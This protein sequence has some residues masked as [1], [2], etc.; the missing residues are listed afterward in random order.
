MITAGSLPQVALRQEDRMRDIS[1]L[2]GEHADLYAAIC[3]DRDF[4][5]QANA[6]IGLLGPLDRAPVTL[7]L[8][9]GP[10]HHSGVL[11]NRFGAS[12]HC[13]DIAAEMRDIAI[14]EGRC[15]Y[16]S[17][18][19]GSVPDALEYEEGSFDLIFVP[20][21]SLGYLDRADLRRTLS[22]VGRLLRESGVF[23]AELH[24]VSSMVHGLTAL[25]IQ[26]REVGF[27]GGMAVCEWP[28]ASPR[29]DDDDWIVSMDVRI[30]VL[31][32]GAPAR[33]HAFISRERI[34]SF[35]EV[36]DL[37][38][39]SGGLTEAAVPPGWTG[40]FPDAAVVV[41]RKASHV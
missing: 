37:A 24:R 12:V 11:R 16:G 34:Y 32:G 3:A 27:D 5:A 1:A 36:A 35:G 40:I 9:A 13:I 28:A 8:F 4:E 15:A 2:Y 38:F 39:E 23:V 17:Y 21:F 10:A 26:T 41:L 19:V 33:E 30:T 29:W 18:R 25:G 14:S 22:L 31:R 6:L 7:E 20:R